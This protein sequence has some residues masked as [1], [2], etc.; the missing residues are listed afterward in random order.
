MGG[1][2]PSYWDVTKTYLGPL[3]G[4]A[5]PYFFA[6]A[7]HRPPDLPDKGNLIG[8]KGIV[9]AVGPPLDGVGRSGGFQSL[10][11]ADLLGACQAPD[12]PLFDMTV[13]S[14]AILAGRQSP[15]EPP[16]PMAFSGGPRIS[17]AAAKK[18]IDAAGP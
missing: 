15:F 2:W 18:I 1:D 6:N 16:P 5:L 8:T 10:V 13:R 14:P 17:V 7:D 12:N 3:G 11:A 9:P 4:I